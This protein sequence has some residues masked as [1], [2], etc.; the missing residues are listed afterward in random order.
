MRRDLHGGHQ[1]SAS[2][3]FGEEVYG[4][5]FRTFTEVP[6]SIARVFVRERSRVTHYQIPRKKL[7]AKRPSQNSR[8]PSVGLRADGN[9]PLRRDWEAGETSSGGRSLGAGGL[10]QGARP[11]VGK[12]EVGIGEREGRARR[13][14]TV[15]GAVLPRAASLLHSQ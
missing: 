1:G 15:F 6:I 7:A 3:H 12:A 11:F 13:G 14:G 2:P 10:W 5:N 8:V 4:G 9:R